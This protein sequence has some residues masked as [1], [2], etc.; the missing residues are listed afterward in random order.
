M[1]PNE[2]PDGMLCKPC[3]VCG[4]AYGSQWLREEVPADVLAFLAALPESALTPAWV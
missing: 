4:Y 1:Y 2:H 3:E